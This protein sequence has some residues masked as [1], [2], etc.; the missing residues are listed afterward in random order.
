MSRGDVWGHPSRPAPPALQG[1]WC[2]SVSTTAACDLG[3]NYHRNPV[4]LDTATASRVGRQLKR[5]QSKFQTSYL[6]LGERTF[7]SLC[8][9][10]LGLAREDGQ[11]PGGLGQRDALLGSRQPPEAELMAEQMISGSKITHFQSQLCRM[12]CQGGLGCFLLLLLEMKR[13]LIDT[14]GEWF[15]TSPDWCNHHIELSHHRIGLKNVSESIKIKWEHRKNVGNS[16]LTRRELVLGLQV[17][18]TSQRTS[19]AGVRWPW[20]ERMSVPIGNVTKHL[21]VSHYLSWS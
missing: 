7:S 10:N 11:P 3:L 12:N 21:S 1:P 14:N 2:T 4:S 20:D 8:P 5:I 15:K 6:N 17:S 9:G 16:C 19:A 18:P 13:F